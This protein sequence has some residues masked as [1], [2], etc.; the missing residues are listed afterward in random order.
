MIGQRAAAELHVMRPSAVIVRLIAI[1]CLVV[2][3]IAVWWWRETA[4][5]ESA[6]QECALL[7]TALERVKG[8]LGRYPEPESTSLPQSLV[9]RCN[10]QPVGDHYLLVVG[11]SNFNLQAYEYDSSTQ[12]WQWD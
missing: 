9:A 2:A 1:L 3:G 5:V 10:Y 6:A 8:E 12:R 4:S 11:G 7:I